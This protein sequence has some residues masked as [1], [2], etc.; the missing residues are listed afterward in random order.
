MNRFWLG[1]GILVSFLVLSL[2]CG[3][4]MGSFH[5]DLAERMETASREA[6]AG[7]LEKAVTEADRVQRS[8]QAHWHT[9][10]ALADHAPMDEI[11][12]LFAQLEAY[13]RA[14]K[15]TEFAAYSARLSRLL[16]A[17]GEAHLPTWWN[18]L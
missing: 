9:T 13:A 10:A 3:W 5:T 15:A 16:H 11:D 6:L 14:E 2:W 12:S 4:V 18:L 1:V 8:W 17:T 7:D